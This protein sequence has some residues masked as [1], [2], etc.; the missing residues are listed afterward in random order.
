M[1]VFFM[2]T[3]NQLVYLI[4]PCVGLEPESKVLECYY[5]GEG[6]TEDG[7]ALVPQGATAPVQKRT[8]FVA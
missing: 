3:H 2:V 4:S 5:C 6:E 1:I 8:R 7:G